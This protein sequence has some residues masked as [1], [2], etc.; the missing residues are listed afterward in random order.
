METTPRSSNSSSRRRVRFDADIDTDAATT[1]PMPSSA[2]ASTSG[3]VRHRPSPPSTVDTPSPSSARANYNS[4]SKC[5][6]GSPGI[7]RVLFHTLS[8][9][10]P[11]AYHNTSSVIEEDPAAAAGG[12]IDD[13]GSK[14]GWQKGYYNSNAVL[15]GGL[16][17]LVA[18]A[19]LAVVSISANSKHSNV[20][21]P[22]LH[23]VE[24]GVESDLAAS[25]RA[26]RKMVRSLVETK[27]GAPIDT[28]AA[29]A[30]FSNNKSKRMAQHRLAPVEATVEAEMDSLRRENAD[31]HK[32]NEVL[33]ERNDELE[34]R[35]AAA[36]ERLLQND[37]GDDEDGFD[38]EV[39]GR[40]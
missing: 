20:D 24:G 40:K 14:T 36:L 10:T 8:S 9:A 29:A 39:E 19:V 37:D 25:V 15:R 38:K 30:A 12:Y 23:M 21:L 5:S 3:R 17:I 28:D 2:S 27:A 13:I 26:Q 33:A 35:M 4:G 11:P 6:N 34:R 7:S 32:R 16:V 18:T 1:L 31:L 22:P